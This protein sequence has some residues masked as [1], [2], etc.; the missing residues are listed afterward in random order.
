MIQGYILLGDQE[1]ARALTAKNVAKTFA[2]ARADWLRTHPG[3]NVNSPSSEYLE[4]TGEWVKRFPDETG[5]W[6]ERLTTLA[7]SESAAAADLE[8]AGDGLIA[9]N[10]RKPE[11]WSYQPVSLRVAQRW[12]ASDIRLRD[13]A[14]LAAKALDE[15]D[16]PRAAT[17]DRL[18]AVPD[19]ARGNQESRLTFART[20]A[21]TAEAGAYR[22]L[23]EFDSAQKTLAQMKTWLHTNPVD[24]ASARNVY[25][26]ATAELA[27]AKGDKASALDAYARM[28]R[29]DSIKQRALA[30]WR[31]LGRTPGGFEAW[32]A[33]SAASPR[34]D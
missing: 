27:E 6:D 4:A 5:A 14:Q 20:Q 26:V 29:T 10:G 13:C 1:S 24:A 12:M 11:Q 30:L 21:Y 15:L 9:A 28:W 17:D 31:E 34:R 7:R 19:T 8:T 22:K 18:P 32:W 25:Y 23:R 33:E 2:A 16:H 3:V